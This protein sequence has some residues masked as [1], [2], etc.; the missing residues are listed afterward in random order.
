MNRVRI[1]LA[2]LALAATGCF[3]T[4]YN[5][6]LPAGTEVKKDSASFYLYGL[7]GEKDLNL[8]ELCPNG[9]SSWKQFAS[10]GDGVFAACTCGI[11]T[12]QEIEVT[13]A[14]GAGK[15]SFLLTPD[16]KN[17]RTLVQ[18]MATACPVKTDKGGQS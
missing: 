15:T 9:V 8:S 16:N 13:C 5:T 10:F 18:P 3:T 4:T 12:P 6:G 17:H 11:Y 1:A 2:G 14:S 7:V